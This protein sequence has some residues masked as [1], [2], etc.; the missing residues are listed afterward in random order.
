MQPEQKGYSEKFFCGQ[1]KKSPNISNQGVDE[2]QIKTRA[3]QTR[4]E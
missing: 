4:N 3:D 2:R 1:Q